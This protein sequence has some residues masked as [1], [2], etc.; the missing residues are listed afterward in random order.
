[1]KKNI[2]SLLQYKNSGILRIVSCGK[3]KP[4]L[5]GGFFLF[6]SLLHSVFLPKRFDIQNRRNPPFSLRLSLSLQHVA[7]FWAA[8][9]FLHKNPD[10]NF[11]SGFCR[12]FMFS[13]ESFLCQLQA[14][15]LDFECP[16]IKGYGVIFHSNLC[17]FLFQHMAFEKHFLEFLF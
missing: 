3:E 2:R 4:P 6:H 15:G 10:R 9:P 1:M 17:F 14:Q 13:D 8:T 5:T 16:E 11:S 7:A 12:G